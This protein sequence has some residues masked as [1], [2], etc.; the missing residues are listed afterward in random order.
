MYINLL[1]ILI[2]AAC[3]A[4]LAQ[5]GIWSNL[6]TLINVITAALLAVNY[7]EPAADWLESKD[8]SYT[9]LLDFVV[10]WGIFGFSAA[11]LRAATD[12]LSK[13]K[14]RFKKPIDTGVGIFLACWIGWVLICFT[15]MTLHTAPLALNF[16][17]F[18]PEPSSRMFIGPAPDH[19]WL[20]FVQKESTGALSRKAVV[21]QADGKVTTGSRKFDPDGEFI[22][23]YGDRRAKLEEH[24]QKTGS[25]RVNQ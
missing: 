3:M 12:S 13:V 6:I 21:K 9:Y 1:L 15:T 2:F 8:N 22:L 16:M 19:V 20:G 7:W 17:G 10:L 14:V 18:Q 23:K 4:S 25:I 5:A 24:Y 11:F